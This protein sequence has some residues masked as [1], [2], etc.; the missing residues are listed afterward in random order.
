MDRWVKTFMIQV[1]LDLIHMQCHCHPFVVNPQAN[2]SSSCCFSSQLYY[3][4]CWVSGAQQEGVSRRIRTSPC[5]ETQA[6]SCVVNRICPTGSV[7]TLPSFWLVLL[8]YAKLAMILHDASMHGLRFHIGAYCMHSIQTAA[9]L[10]SG[11]QD[12]DAV[13]FEGT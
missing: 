1:I 8:T 6:A 3:M 9:G 7:N 2:I 10:D 4:Y 13:Q 11:L 12:K 5:F